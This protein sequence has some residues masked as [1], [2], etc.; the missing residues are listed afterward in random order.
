MTKQNVLFIKE[1]A[2]IL[3]R[4]PH[5]LRRYDY[6]NML[7]AKRNT[8]GHRYYTLAQLNKFKREYKHLYK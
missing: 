4:T 3:G 1:A 2:E 7:K 6:M 8:Y 5:T